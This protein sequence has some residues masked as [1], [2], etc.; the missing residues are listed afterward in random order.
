MYF[1]IEKRILRVY[2]YLVHRQ[3]L[4]FMNI[5]LQYRYGKGGGDWGMSSRTNS[6]QKDFPFH[7]NCRSYI[8][9][10]IK[11]ICQG[12][13][14]AAYTFFQYMYIMYSLKKN[15]WLTLFKSD[16]RSILWLFCDYKAR[17]FFQNSILLISK[18]RIYRVFVI[19][20]APCLSFLIV[21]LIW[22]KLY[23]SGEL[24]QF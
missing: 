10:F 16:Q 2:H 7:L 4:W 6:I 20:P 19:Y 21:L 3:L 24:F 1:I 11:E 12:P 23:V 22:K 8:S 9:F 18:Y 15:G 5:F 13:Y 17:Q 14:T